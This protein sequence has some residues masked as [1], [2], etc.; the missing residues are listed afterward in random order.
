MRICD[1]PISEYGGQWCAGHEDDD[2]QSPVV[3]QV[4]EWNVVSLAQ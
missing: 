1:F 3:S 4:V 2:R